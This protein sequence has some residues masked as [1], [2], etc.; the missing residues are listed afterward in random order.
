MWS[1]LQVR[2]T[3][4]KKSEKDKE[5]EDF[6]EVTTLGL[7]AH[8]GAFAVVR[9][10]TQGSRVLSTEVLSGPGAKGSMLLAFQVESQKYVFDKAR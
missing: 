7:V 2:W 5:P 3:V 8:K 10:T 1:H 4:A 6:P 9:V